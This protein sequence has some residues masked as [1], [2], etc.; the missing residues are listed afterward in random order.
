MNNPKKHKKN[1]IKKQIQ[2]R[3]KEE[4]ATE[5]KHILLQL[6][7]FDLNMQSYQTIV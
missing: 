4:R 2:Y 5:V 6:T 1:K 7:H 3:T